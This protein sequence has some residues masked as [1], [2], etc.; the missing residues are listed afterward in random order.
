MFFNKKNTDNGYRP[1]GYNYGGDYRSSNYSTQR[2]YSDYNAGDDYG[3]G[4]DAYAQPQ[5]TH[6][7]DQQ[8][9]VSEYFG[10]TFRWMAFGLLVTFVLAILTATT[11]LMSVVYALYLPL[12]IGELVLVWVLSARIQK[13]QVMT[14]RIMFL[15]Y[16]ALNGMVMSFYFM[17]FEVSTLILAFL[18]AGLYFGLLAGYGAVTKRDLSSWGPKLMMGL[19]ALIVVSFI[20]MFTGFGYF[21]SMIY[22]GVGLVIFMLLTAYDTQKLYRYYEYYSNSGEMMEKTAVFGALHLYLDFIN[23]FIFLLRMFG[24]R[25]SD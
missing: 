5:Y 3:T 19:V 1:E 15:A 4:S 21:T 20:G 6:R 18:A 8:M 7:G 14:A 16:A 2:N 11:G 9:T 25:R 10:K 12:T 13:M 17:A 24:T 23:I 22:S